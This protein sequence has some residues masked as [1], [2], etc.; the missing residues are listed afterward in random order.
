MLLIQI[1]S[2]SFF[3]FDSYFRCRFG[4]MNLVDTYLKLKNVCGVMELLILVL[5]VFFEY[6][7]TELQKDN[8]NNNHGTS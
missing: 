6:A 4:L 8:N 1:N 2:L 3:I 7:I 5:N